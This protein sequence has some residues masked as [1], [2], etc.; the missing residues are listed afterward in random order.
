MAKAF[1]SHSSS[2]KGLVSKIAQQLGNARCV[3]DEISFEPGRKTIDEIFRTLEESDV[4][5]F[6]ISHKSIESPWVKKELSRANVLLKEEELARIIPIVIEP[7]IT[8]KTPGIPHWLAR[9]YNIKYVGSPVLIKHM[10]EKA[11]RE[12][13]IKNKLNQSGDNIFVGR[14]DELDYFE[15]DINNVDFWMPTC[16]IAHSFYDGM[17]RRTFLKYALQ[18]NNIV[19][20]PYNPLIINLDAN[21]SVESFICRL[22]MIE[23]DIH[24]EK[25]DFSTMSFEAKI[26][27]AIDSLS[28]FCNHGEIIFFVDPG[29]IILP[30][31][32]MTEWFYR[33]L[34]ADVFENNLVCCLLS[35][36]RPRN[37]FNR[38][39]IDDLCLCY[40]ITELSKS[41]TQSL[42]VQLL[43]LYAKKQLT[44]DEAVLFLDQL[45]GIPNQ[46]KYAVG[47]ISN[48][49]PYAKQH[50]QDIIQYSDNNNHVIVEH[51]RQDA[52]N[53][54]I[55]VLLLLAKSDV[56]KTDLIYGTF[57][58]FTKDEID[59]VLIYFSN[60]SIITYLYGGFE[61]V[62]LASSLSD[63]LNRNQ[64]RLEGKYNIK[65]KAIIKSLISQG[66][67]KIL[68]QDY[69]QFLLTLQ[70]MIE[71]HQA[72]PPK[73]FIPSFILR[74]IIR[75]YDHGKYDT[76]IE[77][78]E[79]L[80]N[81]R[82]SAN[83]IVREVK[84]YLALSYARRGNV[85]FMDIIEDFRETQ[86]DYLF[87]Y[88]FYYRIQ[89]NPYSLKKAKECFEQILNSN[90][91]NKKAKREMVNTLLAQE[92]YDE[93]IAYARENYLSDVSSIF[94]I[95]SY[96]QALIKQTYISEE[97]ALIIEQ[98]MDVMRK[99][100]GKKAIDFFRCMEGEFTYYLQN[101]YDRAIELL[102]NAKKKNE[103]DE[104]PERA[105]KRINRHYENKNNR[106]RRRTK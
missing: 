73:Y 35:T 8:Y 5:V 66:L 43:K 79:D 49:L 55:Q 97:D 20:T 87:L 1:L 36:Y 61:Y 45:K 18:K 84:Y 72:I 34:R 29:A 68:S 3:F 89:D 64:Y 78:C 102:E 25:Y 44:R 21:E 104:Y 31:G 53:W 96:F 39:A 106:K 86:S 42:F 38:K 69:S 19:R 41:D 93:A 91:N 48:N 4:F 80:L 47:L 77:M 65:L 59:E 30:N 12:V 56:I 83:E 90:P 11:L 40:D 24:P 76:V 13:H 9:P 54:Y 99:R 92:Q 95:H 63:Y 62:H 28:L 2:D 103:N 14:Y 82:N 57:D 88:G 75:E 15:K 33:A 105:I 101:D 67:D 51:I 37:V 46:I 22:G 94:H 27:L 98:L 10:I 23:K 71:D 17:G 52:S 100:K 16:I 50:I 58:D 70:S 6:F 7:D 60:L 26:E 32:T 85:K 81:N 74:G